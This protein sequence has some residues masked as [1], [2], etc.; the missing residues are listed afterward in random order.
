MNISIEGLIG[1][2]GDLQISRI[3]HKEMKS[4]RKNIR[5][6]EFQ[7]GMKTQHRK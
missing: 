6:L 3:K 5:K 4:K 2:Q 1:N 7:F